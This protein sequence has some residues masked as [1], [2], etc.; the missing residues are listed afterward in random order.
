MKKIII[1]FLFVIV[2][3]WSISQNFDGGIFAGLTT[4]Q[5]DGDRFSGYNKAGM[6]FGGFVK[7]K[8]SK[9]LGAQLEIKYIQKGSRKEIKP[10]KGDYTYYK[11]KLSYAEVPVLLNYYYKDKFIIEAGLAVGYLISSYEEGSQDGST[12]VEI[13]PDDSRPFKN[14]ELSGLAGMNYLISENFIANFRF[15][16][17]IFPIRDHP[18]NQTYYFDRGQYNNLLSFALYY[19]F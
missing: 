11:M 12:V 4:T 3:L 10:D 9:T 15:S 16:Y 19:Q 6:L 2:P 5:V 8:L 14:I 13:Y 7:N 17:S 1:L 18:G